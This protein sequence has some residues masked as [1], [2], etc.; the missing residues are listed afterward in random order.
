MA[1]E[2]KMVFA[3]GAFTDHWVVESGFRSR[4]GLS[5]HVHGVFEPQKRP[6][7]VISLRCQMFGA[8]KTMGSK[9]ETNENS[10]LSIG[11]MC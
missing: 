10:L 1:R 8:A 2:F 11:R 5:N 9:E 6:G 7:D 4:Q 3:L